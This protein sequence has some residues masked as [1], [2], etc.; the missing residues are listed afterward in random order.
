M[1]YT[2]PRRASK[3]FLKEEPFLPGSSLISLVIPKKEGFLRR[4]YCLHCWESVKEEKGSS[5]WKVILP[6]KAEESKSLSDLQA[7][8]LFCSLLGKEKELAFVLALYLERKKFLTKRREGEEELIFENNENG[9][10]Y[11]VEKVPSKLL[12]FKKILSSLD[13]TYKTSLVASSD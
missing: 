10:L 11:I 1:K 7:L 8:E 13:D 3:C 5:F 12:D 2:L 4:D 6:K 9:E